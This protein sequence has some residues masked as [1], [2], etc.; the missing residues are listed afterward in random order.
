MTSLRTLG[1]GALVAL[2]LCSCHRKEP[3]RLKAFPM[4]VLWA[5]E[6]PQD[7]RFLK[8]R[9]VGIAFYAKHV[10]L[11]GDRVLMRPRVAP[12]R[13]DEETPLMAVVRVD[14]DARESPV[15][16]AAQREALLRE[17]ED[18]FALPRV[19]ALQIDFDARVSE[20][21]FYRDLLWDLRKRHPQLP[22]SITAL[23]SW[24]LDDPWIRNLPVD[25]AVPMLFRMGGGA[26]K[27]R[28]QV[29]QGRDFH[30]DS[31]RNALGLSTDEPRD[32]VPAGWRRSRRVYVFQGRPW[33]EENVASLLQELDR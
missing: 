27:V 23:A 6:E 26:A 1:A 8:G 31:A 5:W 18:A 2:A 32:M 28:E 16:D 4:R 29:R 13:V 17:L 21:A 22:V 15:L 25:E 24:C 10:L 12:L 14:G 7:L 33:T 3:S 30:A 11:R 9:N 19:V 20:R